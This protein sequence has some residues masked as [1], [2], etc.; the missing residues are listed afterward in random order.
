MRISSWRKVA[1]GTWRSAKDP[2]VY[3]L[4]EVDATK[5]VAFLERENAKSNQHLTMTHYVGRVVAVAFARH[6]QVNCVLRFG[7]LYPRKSVSIFFQVAT[8]EDGQ[9]L[10]GMTIRN[11][12]TKNINVIADEMRK[13]VTKIRKLTDDTYTRMKG[14]M[15]ILPGWCTRFVLDFAGFVQY[16]L[17]LWSPLFGTPKDALGGVMITN[18]GSLGLDLAFAPLVPYSHVP[19]VIAIGKVMDR[20]V[21]RNGQVEAALVVRLGITF[22][23]RLIDGVHASR[24]ASVVEELFADPAM[25]G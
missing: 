1:I 20:A 24:L 4:L 23:H 22:D 16:Q 6:P 7:R 5:A 13:R 15:S 21:V 12:E 3:G 17:N 19:M 10:S 2:S 11:A 14:L 9:D 18:V 25:L 8:D